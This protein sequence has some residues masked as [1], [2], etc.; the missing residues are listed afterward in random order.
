MCL[1]VGQSA[2]VNVLKQ[3]CSSIVIPQLEYATPVWSSLS[4][5]QE[6][7]LEQIQRAY[8]K[9][10]YDYESPLTYPDL[11]DRLNLLPLSYTDETCV[12]YTQI[13]KDP[14]SLHLDSIHFRNNQKCTKQSESSNFPI[15]RCKMSNQENVILIVV[16]SW[17][18]LLESVKM[19]QHY[20]VLRK[21][22]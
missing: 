17:N 5:S 12:S 7:I 21:V 14:C 2:P 1:T 16:Y 18:K 13:I 15:P 19:Q 20:L 9:F 6:Q 4:K 3:L 10:M 8:T 22:K 11:L